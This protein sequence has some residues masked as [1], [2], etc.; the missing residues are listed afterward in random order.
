LTQYLYTYA[1]TGD[2]TSLCLLEQR[3]LFGKDTL[4]HVLESP[5]AIDPTRSPFI[6][7]RLDVI[8]E[9]RCLQDMLEQAADLPVQAA[10]F[11]V[12]VDKNSIDS[13]GGRIRFEQRR[14][15]ERA[16][17][18]RIHGV[19]E[20][21]HP[22]RVYGVMILGE[23]WLFG[24]Y[25]KSKSIWFKHKM[26]PQ[27]Y[28][29]ALSTKAAR[30][31]V[32]IAAPQPE[33]LRVIDPCCGIGT[34]LVEALSMGIDIVGRDINPL[35]TCGAR[36]NIAFFGLSGKVTLGAIQ[37]IEDHYDVAIVDMPYNLCSVITAEEQLTMLQSAA[38]IANRVVIVTIE[39]IDPII[40]RSGL[41]IVDRCI[42]KKRMFERQIIVCEQ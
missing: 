2:E 31:V 17:G 13:A 18:E 14:A 40:T 35:V 29:T 28:S 12:I 34:V 20:L 7:G 25:G 4:A 22:E 32:N 38:R 41:M 30:A 37:N 36:E 3:S 19:A 1:Y 27:S 6:M 10:T 39:S 21:I 26:K 11:K 9:G 42:A 15:M 24:E 5:I 16:I 33:G 8:F 23:R